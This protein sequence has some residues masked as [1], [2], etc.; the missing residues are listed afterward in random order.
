M[1]AHHDRTDGRIFLNDLL[2]R[3]AQLE[4][5]PHPRHV[6]HLA[7]EDFLGQLL[8]TAACGD[9][10]DR[11]RMHV[12]DVLAG[13]KLCSGVSIE[14]ARGFRLK[15]VWVYIADHVVLG[16]RLQTLVACASVE[17]LQIEQ[18]LLV[19]RGEILALRGAQVA[20]GSLHPK[21][22][23]LLA[24]ERILFRDLRGSI[25]AAGVGDALVAAEH[26]RAIDEPADG[27]EFRRERV[28]PKIVYEF[29]SHD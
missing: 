12:I 2:H 20:A 1:L 22:F 27:I 13:M 26:I 17:L 3:Q 9:R 28:I 4:A 11:I 29:I 18:L 24:G 21:H 25:S 14:T 15:V 8:A 6:G 23:D 7:A 10:D 5:G 16:L 19:E